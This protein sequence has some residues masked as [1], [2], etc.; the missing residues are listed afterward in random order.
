MSGLGT[1]VPR[2]CDELFPEA[3]DPSGV[4]PDRMHGIVSTTLQEAK[5][6][7]GSIQDC[8]G[9]E[10]GSLK[11]AKPRSRRREPVRDRPPLRFATAVNPLR[12]IGHPDE[13][14]SGGRFGE[15][16]T[17]ARAG[18]DAGS[19]VGGSKPAKG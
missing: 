14:Q 5:P 18:R 12:V 16:D 13:N 4:D 17:W 8:G 1:L 3:G 2:L 6:K 10:N 7:A 19:P 11:G 9:P 15:N